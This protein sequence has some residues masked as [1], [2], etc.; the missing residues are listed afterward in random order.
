MLALNEALQ[1]AG[2]GLDTRF[3]RVK[4]ALSG[5]ISALLTEQANVGVL[6]SRLSNL[7]I[8]T[9]KTVNPAIVGVEILEH[10]QRLKVHGMSLERYLGE[11]KMELLKREV[12]SSMGIQLKTLPRWLISEDRL[13]EAQTIG[14]KQGSAIVITVKG[15]TEAKKLCASGLR[16]GGLVKVVEKFWEAGLS[17]VC[18]TCCGIGHERMGDCGNR[19]AKCAIYTGAYKVEEHQCGVVG[20]TKGRGKICPR[21]TVKCAN[22]GGNHMANSLRCNSRHKAG[23][24]ANK[25]K[26]LRKQSEKEKEKVVSAD[27]DEIGVDTRN[28]D[29][30]MEMDNEKEKLAQEP[31][32]ENLDLVM[33]NDDWA[34]SPGSS[35]SPY[36]DN[37][38][39]DSANRW[40]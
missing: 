29:S 22:C 20:C 15:E 11:G 25:E 2:E 37:K 6:L 13:R 32:E 28:P 14:S 19:P 9:A 27:G 39:P 34:A 18:M 12:E 38:G 4:Y 26:K 16:F 7:L 31:K 8:R 1:K 17:S 33:E 36:E 30:D 5:A 40:D 35:L 24:K 3:I 23:V 21:I 10:W